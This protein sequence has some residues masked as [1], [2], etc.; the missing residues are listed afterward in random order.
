MIPGL[1][2]TIAAL[3]GRLLAGLLPQLFVA[4]TEIFPDVVPAVTEILLVV[5]EP[6]QP[7]GSVHA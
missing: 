5:E 3:T 4:V 2:G 1:A 6:V 7:D